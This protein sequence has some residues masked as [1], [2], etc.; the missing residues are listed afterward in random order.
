MK[1][2]APPI[3]HGGQIPIIARFFSLDLGMSSHPS[4]QMKIG[5]ELLVKMLIV[6]NVP[7]NRARQT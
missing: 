5:L 1:M 2:V 6:F 4:Q 7:I 3:L